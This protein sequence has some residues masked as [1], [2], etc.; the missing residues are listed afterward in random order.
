MLKKFLTVSAL[1]IIIALI[2]YFIYTTRF[3]SDQNSAQI[4]KNNFKKC[5]D[6][7]SFLSSELDC[8]TIDEDIEQVHNLHKDVGSLIEHEK[9]N[10]SADEISVFFRDLNTRRWF[11]INENI[12]FYPASLAKLPFAMMMYKV[13]EI[14]KEILEEPIK[15]DDADLKLNDGQ[16]YQPPELLESSAIYPVKE[17]LRRMLVFS[18]NAPT[19]KLMDLSA[20]LR[21]PILDDLGVF[22]PP[23]VET[24]EMKWNIT[25]KIYANFFRILY[26]A[27]YLR[28]E[29]SNIILGQLSQS[30]FQNGL[31]SGIPKEVQIAHK[32]GEISQPDEKTGEITT[33]LNDCGIIYKKNSPYI[34]CVMTQGHN[35]SKL[36]QIIKNI[37]ATIYQ[38]SLD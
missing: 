11:G 35:Y 37:S 33:I 23:N 38:S 27:S 13:A 1:I 10:G 32:F 20:P 22:F 18:D 2:G 29:C 26:N 24:G 19:N 14:D 28:P 3:T 4:Q 8:S 31:V 7:Y 12:N 34:L 6:Q 30:T 21:N 17:L 15:I 25:A 9:Q 36:E 16:H 5:S